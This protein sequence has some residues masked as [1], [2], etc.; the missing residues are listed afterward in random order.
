MSFLFLLPFFSGGVRWLQRQKQWV[1]TSKLIV[2]SH[3]NRDLLQFLSKMQGIVGDHERHSMGSY[4]QPGALPYM[5]NL[6]WQIGPPCL[7]KGAPSLC[8]RVPL[9]ASCNP[10][11]NYREQGKLL[12]SRLQGIPIRAT[13]AKIGKKCFHR[14]GPAP[15][16]ASAQLQ[17]RPL[18]A[19][20]QQQLP[21]F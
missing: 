3:N 9:E 11:S 16:L 7:G 17:V 4:V 2:I 15:R 6:L 12:R 10:I 21:A 14:F 1:K 18:L 13:K 20:P 5:S 19:S 8:K